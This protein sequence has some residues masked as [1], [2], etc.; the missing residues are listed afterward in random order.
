M[1]ALSPGIVQACYAESQSE[2]GAVAVRISVCRFWRSVIGHPLPYLRSGSSLLL[3]PCSRYAVRRAASHSV[4]VG[5]LLKRALLVKKP[6][7]MRI[8]AFRGDLVV[9]LMRHCSQTHARAAILTKSRGRAPNDHS[10][11]RKRSRVPPPTRA[12]PPCARRS[13]L[14]HVA[15]WCVRGPGTRGGGRTIATSANLSQPGAPRGFPRHPWASRAT[16]CARAG[17]GPGV[18][19]GRQPGAGCPGSGSPC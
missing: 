2:L 18:G 7:S 4:G 10:R 14:A 6:S 16:I 8:P 12:T 1:P 9:F 3:A 17:A 19:A 5:K 11:Q 15:S 13:S